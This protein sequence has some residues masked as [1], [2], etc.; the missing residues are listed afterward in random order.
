MADGESAGKI[1]AYDFQPHGTT[2]AVPVQIEQPTLGTNL[3]KWTP[4]QNI[5][6]AYFSS[7]NQTA[8]TGE[9][10]EFRPTFV[11][12]DKAWIKFTVDHFSGYMVSTG[13]EEE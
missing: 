8:G 13:R 12:A 6:G 9:V 3:M 4:T 10:T 11:S 1:V 2:F 5:L 7:L